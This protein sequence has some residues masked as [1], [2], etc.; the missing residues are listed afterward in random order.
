[1]K[2]N[3]TIIE[4]A[5]SFGFDTAEYVGEW[6]NYQVFA[7]AMNDGSECPCIGEPIMVLYDGKST[8]Q[9]ENWEWKQIV[10]DLKLT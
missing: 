2:P 9:A 5:Q 10:A 1:M 7:P 8:R 4:L 3:K 6:Q